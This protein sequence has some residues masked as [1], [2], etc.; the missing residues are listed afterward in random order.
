M[1]QA[2]CQQPVEAGRA[3]TALHVANNGNTRI[4]VVKFLFHFFSYFKCSTFFVAFSHY[5]NARRFM[6]L[7]SVFKALYH[8]VDIGFTFRY[9][10]VFGTTAKP[11]VQGNKARI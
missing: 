6:T 2:A 3:A 9:Q 1:P 11:A 4:I 5:Y 8:F 10:Y 7:P